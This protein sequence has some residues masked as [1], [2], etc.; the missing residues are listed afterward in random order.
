MIRIA[1]N[2]DEVSFIEKLETSHNQQLLFSERKTLNA[3]Y[4]NYMDILHNPTFQFCKSDDIGLP[5]SCISKTLSYKN[6]NPAIMRG[7]F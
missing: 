1:N 3:V 7:L 5:E 4:K 2:L 6:R